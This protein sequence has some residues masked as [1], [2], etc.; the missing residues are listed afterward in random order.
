MIDALEL[1]I[2]PDDPENAIYR[3]EFMWDLIGYNEDYIWIQ[4]Y[5]VNPWALSDDAAYD[6]LSVTFWG[7]EFFKSY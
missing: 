4:L 7:V 2:L 3:I 1:Q 6:K 5:F